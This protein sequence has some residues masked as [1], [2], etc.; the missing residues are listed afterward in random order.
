MKD[1]ISSRVQVITANYTSPRLALLFGLILGKR[2][3]FITFGTMRMFSIGSITLV[4]KPFKT[5]FIIW[6]FSHKLHEV[7]LRF[8]GLCPFWFV[9]VRWW[10]F[11][12]PLCIYLYYSILRLYSQGI[13]TFIKGRGLLS[14]LYERVKV[15]SYSHSMVEGGLEVMS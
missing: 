3:D 2:R 10:H 14:R 5:G 4:P 8:R 9:P 13:I 15:Y 1:S 6:K 12:S 7:I 11:S